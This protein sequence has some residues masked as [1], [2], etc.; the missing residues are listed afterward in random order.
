VKFKVNNLQ[1]NCIRHLV[2]TAAVNGLNNFQVGFPTA[3]PTASDP[4]VTTSYTV[5]GT[6]MVGVTLGAEVTVDCAAPSDQQYVI[7]Q[8]LD[9]SAEKL[10][11]AEACVNASSQYA[12]TF[13]SM[14]QQRCI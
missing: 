9:T 6:T 11:I 10:C 5:C 12:V 4:V 2:C 13:V 8:S 3:L 1:S 14:Q 7:I